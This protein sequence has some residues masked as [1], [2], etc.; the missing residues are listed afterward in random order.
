MLQTQVFVATFVWF[1]FEFIPDATGST[2]STQPEPGGRFH[3]R[4]ARLCFHCKEKKSK[5]LLKTSA[6][7]REVDINIQ[8]VR[9]W[10]ISW[11]SWISQVL[12]RVAS[13]MSWGILFRP[14]WGSSMSNYCSTRRVLSSLC[15][16]EYLS[17]HLSY[18]SNEAAS[19]GADDR[20]EHCCENTW[21]EG[22]LGNSNGTW[23]ITTGF[24][25]RVRAVSRSRAGSGGDCRAT[26]WGVDPKSAFREVFICC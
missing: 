22:V 7:V 9:I 21:C 8:K 23:Y 3:W 15:W 20:T 5:S 25:G 6:N 16:D 2:L 19:Q 14:S 11:I 12:I 13:L 24:S 26:S 17:Y 10:N 1:W 4:V 18:T